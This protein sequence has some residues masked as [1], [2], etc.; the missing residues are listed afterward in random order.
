M[1]KTKI[2]EIV[3]KTLRGQEYVPTSTTDADALNLKFIDDLELDS[4]DI[5]ELHTLLEDAFDMR[6]DEKKINNCPTVKHLVN[7]LVDE[8]DADE[9]EDAEDESK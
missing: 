1:T 3:L 6:F 5:V 9:D 7:T 8:L 2:T 4:L